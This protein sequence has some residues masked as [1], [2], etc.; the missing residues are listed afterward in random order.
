MSREFLIKTLS[1]LVVM[2]A[3]LAVQAGPAAA[4]SATK[5]DCKECVK[6]KHLKDGGIKAKDLKD[7]A[8][9]SDKIADGAVTG[10]KIADASVT[11]ADVQDGSLTGADI[12]GLS[13]SDIDAES[14]PSS[15]ISNE[16]GVEFGFLDSSPTIT[17]MDSTVTTVMV[18]APSTG[19]VTIIVTGT[20]EY[21]GVDATVSCSIANQNQNTVNNDNN[22]RGFVSSTARVDSFSNVRTF[23]QAKGSKNYRFNC[24]T[25]DPSEKAD[26]DDINITAMFF[27]TRY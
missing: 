7:G 3:F 22:V 9:E 2:G 5:L 16:P 23:D 21:E 20:F 10:S 4:Q 6:G 11:S 18:S 25:E 19:F 14:V 1:A 13:G 12:A 26:I 8:V 17:G 24:K 15:D 27:P